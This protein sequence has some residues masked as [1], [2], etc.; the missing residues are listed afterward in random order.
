MGPSE[1]CVA[2]VKEMF[3][4]CVL[5]LERLPS[6]DAHLHRDEQKYFPKIVKV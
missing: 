5:S 4:K 2:T 3:R 6:K 1:S